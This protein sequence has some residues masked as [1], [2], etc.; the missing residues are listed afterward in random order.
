MTL[1]TMSDADRENLADFAKMLAQ[2]NKQ[3]SKES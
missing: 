2:K 3:K 1:A